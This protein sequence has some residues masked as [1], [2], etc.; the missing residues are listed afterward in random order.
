M[1]GFGFKIVER[2]RPEIEPIVERALADRCPVEVGLYFGEP[3]VR[4]YLAD[5]LAPSGL[6]VAVHLDHRQLSTF[7][8]E[9]RETLL[10]EQLATAARLGAAYVITHLSPYPM[11]PRPELRT[12]LLDKLFA[13]L[14]HARRLCAEY[15][16][17]LHI[18]NTYHEMAFYRRLFRGLVASDL[19][20][21]HFC[22]DIGHAKVWSG[23]TL[24]QWLAFLSELD[25]EG[26][27][28]HFHLH[29]NRGLSD[30]HL[31]FLTAERLG[32]TGPDGFTGGL[33]YYQALA[34]IGARF[35]QASKVFEVPADEAVANLDHVLARMKAARAAAA[36]GTEA[37]AQAGAQTGAQ[38]AKGL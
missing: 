27:R 20:P 1:P 38:V 14:R 22:F 11:T 2:S 18:E 9:A 16:L 15:G 23:E 37:K 30:E 12:A 19:D 6:P 28:L 36:P 7:S 21:I 33:D 8:I 10:R 34:E 5:Q 26:V 32:I 4:D 35:A 25:A 24:A 13:G 17:D 3:G 31:S 29:A